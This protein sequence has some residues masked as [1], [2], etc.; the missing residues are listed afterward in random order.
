MRGPAAVNL[1]PCKPATPTLRVL[2]V[3]RAPRSR[4]PGILPTMPPTHSVLTEPHNS[5]SAPYCDSEKRPFREA[6]QRV[7][8][9]A[10]QGS[11]RRPA[12]ESH[13]YAAGLASDLVSFSASLRYRSAIA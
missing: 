5:V 10:R 11:A 6:A 1:A 4:N 9:S 3:A 8:R 7:G 2:T 13:G 12:V